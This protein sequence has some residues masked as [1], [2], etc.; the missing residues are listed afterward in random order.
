MHSTPGH[1]RDQFI[2]AQESGWIGPQRSLQRQQLQPWPWASTTSLAEVVE[3]EGDE[4]GYG[5]LTC[6]RVVQLERPQ[7]LWAEKE[8]EGRKNWRDQ[9]LAF[10][11]GIFAR[12]QSRDLWGY[13]PPLKNPVLFNKPKAPG[14]KHTSPQLCHHPFFFPSPL[15]VFLFML[16]AL[17]M[18]Q[19]R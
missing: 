3:G 19:L 11:C 8:G 14:V 2:C 7:L 17:V 12:R 9:F 13:P 16:P 18:R 4:L 6:L 10:C 1:P 5:K 15:A